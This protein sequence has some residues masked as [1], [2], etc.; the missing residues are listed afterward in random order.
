MKKGKD[1]KSIEKLGDTLIIL[2]NVFF[3]IASLISYKKHPIL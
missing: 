1:I 3:M 2:S